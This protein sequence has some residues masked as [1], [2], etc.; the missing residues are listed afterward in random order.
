MQPSEQ[1][2][3]EIL[4]KIDS[5][6]DVKKLSLD[7][8]KQL[9]DEVRRFIIAHVVETGGHLAPS[10]GVVELTLALHAVFDCPN[11]KIVW[12]VGHQTYAH[13]I[14]TGRRDQFC[15][16][17]QLD[18]L[19]GFPKRRESAYDAFDTG[20]SS[21]SISA[22]LGMAVGKRLRGASGKVL[23]VIGDG[24]LTGGMAY[25]GLN[26]AGFLNEDLIVVLNDNG[27]SIAPNVGA[28]SKFVSRS[29]SGGA[30]QRFR[31]E[32]ERFL[33][34]MPG[35]GENLVEL[36]RRAEESFRA[37]FSPSMLFEAFRFNYVGPVDGHDLGRL[38]N[39]FGNVA[40]I[41]GPHLIHVITQK[42]KG[43]R[44]AEENP[45]HFHGVGKIAQPPATADCGLIPPPKPKIQTYTEVFGRT[46][47][48]LAK[49]RRDI[50]AITA[51]MPEGTGLQSFAESYRD[52]FI[53]VGIAEQHAV[54][55]A[56]GLACEGFR[57]VVAIYSTFMQ[58]AFD[59][60]VHDVCLP[61]L[62]V[63][64]AMDRAGVVGEDGETHQGLLDLSFLRCAPNLS[65]M[66]PADENE[67]RHMLF[68]ALDHDG[69][70]A[71][72]YP[73]GAGL[74]AHTDEP[75]R[76]LPWGKGQLLSDGGDVLLVG[77]GVGVELCRLAGVM[78][79]AEGVSA[80]V[81][82][83]RF[84]K[85]L[86][87]ELICQLAQRCGRVVTVEEN[88]LAG[89]FGAAV[90]EALAAHGLRPKTRLIGVNDRYVEHGAQGK[91]RQ[92]LG[93]TPEAVAAAARALLA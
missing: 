78:L 47:V 15:T 52:R 79:S 73:R 22:A 75:L 88:M 9:A 74:G 53:D 57:P 17:R 24:S 40:P 37:F 35:V 25:E 90:L 4:A 72:R 31:K 85:P 62:P 77:I 65:I 80:A 6:A 32:L 55:F 49:E 13:K 48:Q 2:T 19:S 16:L 5:P 27:M 26:Q 7:Q 8:L 45:A 21:T 42:G 89:G 41:K 76:P 39:V 69:P 84:V 11:D 93:L 81:V 91:L 64:L 34:N 20:H 12:D 92:R 51:A 87:D 56:A 58:R 59:Q 38:I 67:L 29:L 3:Y 61:K 23:A 46:M 36:A 14:I 33:K 1:T 86:D 71:L 68:S 44:P 28:L 82:N 66:A 83:A 63:V 10:L 60:V 18:G 50:V 43:Y 70:T 54:T 30:Y